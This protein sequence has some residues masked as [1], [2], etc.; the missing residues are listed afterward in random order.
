MAWAEAYPRTKWHLDPSSRL[1]TIHGPKLRVLCPLFGG[2]WVPSNTMSPGPRPTSV[3]SGILIHQAVWPQ[4][5]WA[6]N[7]EVVPFCGRGPMGSHLTQCGRGRN[8]PPCQ[9]SSGSIQPFGHNTPTSQTDR[10]DNCPIAYGV[11]FYKRSPK[12]EIYSDSSRISGRGP[13][14]SNLSL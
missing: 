14:I 7:R 8:L 9:V 12:N 10:T 1:A 11:P 4:Q 5:T 3:P 2:G 6:K 13:C